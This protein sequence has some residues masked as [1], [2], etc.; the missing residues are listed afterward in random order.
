MRGWHQDAGE[1]D[2]PQVFAQPLQLIV[3]ALEGAADI[4]SLHAQLPD[5]ERLEPEL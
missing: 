3:E 4:F 5:A 2:F 1:R